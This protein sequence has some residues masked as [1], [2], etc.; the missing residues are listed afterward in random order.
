MHPDFI[1]H[2]SKLEIQAS[3]DN[4][5]MKYHGVEPLPLEFDTSALVSQTMSV[6]SSLHTARACC[7]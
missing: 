2:V 7:R 1:M 5:R 3:K 6:K 4:I